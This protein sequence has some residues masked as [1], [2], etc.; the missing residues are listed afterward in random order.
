ME[1]ATLEA[2]VP[3]GQVR[4]AILD[5]AGRHAGISKMQLTRRLNVSWGTTS[6]LVSALE[7]EGLLH[8]LRG[9]KSAT[10]FLRSA[11]AAPLPWLLAVR[12]AETQKILGLFSTRRQITV[13]D[14]AATS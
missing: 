9:P 8:V 6:Y 4:T 14:A 3:R 13:P 1:S 5:L 2:K 11:V 10:V 12:Q 7:A